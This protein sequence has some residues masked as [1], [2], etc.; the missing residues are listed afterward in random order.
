[1]DP[2][3]INYAEVVSIA[4]KIGGSVVVSILFLLGYIWRTTTTQIKG[5][6]DLS[7][8]KER[9]KTDD[10]KNRVINEE[11]KGIKQEHCKLEKT[12][13]EEFKDLRK[14]IDDKDEKQYTYLKEMFE[15]KDKI[16]NLILEELKYIRGRVDQIPT[17]NTGS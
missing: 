5:K 9:F 6:A 2:Q 15:E 3:E 4:W 11:I 8:L 17:K 10:E 1:M 16:N 13:K 7:V 12:T 14:Y